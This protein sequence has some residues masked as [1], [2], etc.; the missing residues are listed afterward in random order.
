MGQS[1]AAA[2]N[3][4]GWCGNANGHRWVPGTLAEQQRTGIA[5]AHGRPC[6]A[7]R[8]ADRMGASVLRSG[9][10]QLLGRRTSLRPW[11]QGPHCTWA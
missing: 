1:S 10:Q 9:R 4:T 2:V 7:L 8:T 5:P 3:T 6:Q 11:P